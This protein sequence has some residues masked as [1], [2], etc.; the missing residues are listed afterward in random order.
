MISTS[1]G[2][3]YA[4]ELERGRRN[5][6]VPVRG[7]VVTNDSRLRI[8]LAERGAGLAYVMEPVVAEQLK[9]GRLQRVLEPFAAT[10]PG[11]F[12][13]FPSRAR[14]SPALRAFVETAKELVASPTA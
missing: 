5:W 12:L 3:L 2:A 14:R 13:Y 7:G 11:F 10:V 8:S 4:W 1:T 6:R 9:K